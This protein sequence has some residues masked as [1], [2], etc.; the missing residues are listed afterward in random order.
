M[1]AEPEAKNTRERV[2][3]TLLVRER[4]TI[5]ELAEAGA[6][7]A[8]VDR[9]FPMDEAAEAVRYLES[10]RAEGKVVLVM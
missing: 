4:V 7:R 1:L 5:N 3:R 9:R 10:G 2:L 8:I 6:I